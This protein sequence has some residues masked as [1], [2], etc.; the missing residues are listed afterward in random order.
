MGIEQAISSIVHG[1][2]SALSKIGQF[3]QAAGPVLSKAAGPLEMAGGAAATAMGQPQ[4]GIPMMA[5]GMSGMGGGTPNANMM[6]G[7]APAAQQAMGGQQPPQPPP[8]PQRQPPAGGGQMPMPQMQSP[9]PGPMGGQQRP[10]LPPQ[11][12]AALGLS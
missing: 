8:M 12:L 9:V 7:M 6:M 1:G 5:G 2:E 11:L 3:G 4:I 10:Q